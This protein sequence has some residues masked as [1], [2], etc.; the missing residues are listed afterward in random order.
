MV[1][2]IRSLAGAS[3]AGTPGLPEA[4]P[5]FS[6]TSNFDIVLPPGRLPPCCVGSNCY[7]NRVWSWISRAQRPWR[8]WPDCVGL[9]C[10]ILTMF[11]LCSFS[12]LAT[13]EPGLMYCIRI[14]AGSTDAAASPVETPPGAPEPASC[15]ET[16][17]DVATQ[18]PS[19]SPAGEVPAAQPERS[20]VPTLQIP[21]KEITSTNFKKEWLLLGR[22]AA[23]P[24][25]MEFPQIAKAFGSGTKAEQRDVLKRYLQNGGN[26]EAIEAT[27]TVERSHE[28][29][30][31]GT[32]A[33]LTI[34]QMR[35]EGCSER[36]GFI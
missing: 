21:E 22:V 33:L 31:E 19:A 27:F 32:R 20:A 17:V 3:F 23:G 9:K 18:V 2:P 7:A 13:V 11:V 25:A 12:L 24:R 30:H 34:D 26:L 15:G 4:G 14:R 35:K 1:L 8:T 10:I 6:N 5:G 36:L 29:E 16:Q 28:G